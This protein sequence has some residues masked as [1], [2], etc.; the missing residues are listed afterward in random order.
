MCK[1]DG[2]G[3]LQYGKFLNLVGFAS[4]TWGVGYYHAATFIYSKIDENDNFYHLVA[5]PNENDNG[6]STPKYIIKHNTS[7]TIAWQYKIGTD[8]W[9]GHFQNGNAPNY[10]GF[11]VTRD[12]SAVYLLYKNVQFQQKILI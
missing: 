8:G 6:F 5:V 2:S 11:A 12:G 9:A 7:E 4:P 1:L 3:N 10:Q